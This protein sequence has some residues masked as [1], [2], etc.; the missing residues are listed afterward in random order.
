MVERGRSALGV[1][2]C[3]C[4]HQ[5]FWTHHGF[6]HPCIRFETYVPHILRAWE[7]PREGYSGSFCCF[8]NFPVLH[9]FQG[10]IQ[11]S[12]EAHNSNT[13]TRFQFA[14]SLQ[15]IVISEYGL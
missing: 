2:H 5:D 13:Q 8:G 3:M 4:F 7:D 9:V 14:F 15:I 1:R 6:T 10:A 12:L 11:S